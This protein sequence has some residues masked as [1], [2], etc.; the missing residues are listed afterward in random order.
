ML[1]LSLPLPLLSLSP[2]VRC[3][4]CECILEVPV[5]ADCGHSVC[6]GCVK[7]DTPADPT[8][9]PQD[10]TCPLCRDSVLQRAI[11][12]Y[13]ARLRQRFERVDHGGTQTALSAIYTE[14]LVTEAEAEA[15][16]SETLAHQHEVW[17]LESSY[18][19][20]RSS[21]SSS[22]DQAEL[23]GTTGKKRKNSG[24][25]PEPI[26][27]NNVFKPCGGGR[28][29]VKTVMT[30]G[31]AGVGKT[32][33][34]HRFVLDWADG[35]A[36][37]DVDFIFVFSFGTLNAIRHSW[38]NLHGLLLRLH[39][40]LKELQGEQLYEEC[41]VVL[42]FDGLDESQLD[43]NFQDN[44]VLCDTNNFASVDVLVTNL[45][46][47]NL[48]PSAQ[49]WVTS[50]PSAANQIPARYVDRVTEIHGFT[51]QQREE[52]FRKRLCE[53]GG[54]GVRNTLDVAAG[55]THTD[56]DTH[57][58][59]K[60]MVSQIKSCRSL[61][62][63][64]Q[65][66]SLCCIAAALFPYMLA[67]DE[68]GNNAKLVQ[69]KAGYD[70]K[71]AQV[72]TG[73][74]T[75]KLAL[76][77]TANSSN[78]PQ[79]LTE[80]FIHFLLRQ[81]HLEMEMFHGGDSHA[82][83]DV[84][85]SP[86]TGTSRKE[87]WHSRTS[88]H[89]SLD[90]EAERDGSS[91]G[92]TDR[93]SPWHPMPERAA[94]SE[95]V[96]AERTT[97][98]DAGVSS[99]A[100]KNRNT[101]QD[102]EASTCTPLDAE[103]RGKASLH[104]GIDRKASLD[105]AERAPSRDT[106]MKS[107]ASSETGTKRKASR[108]LDTTSTK[109]SCDV[110]VERD[111]SLDVVA[112]RD[113]PSDAGTWT[114]VMWDLDAES[115]AS[116]DAGEKRDALS[117]AGTGRKASSDAGTSRKASSYSGTRR[118]VSSALGTERGASSNLEAERDASLERGT[119]RK[120]SSD[121]GTS[122]DVSSALGM[123][124]DE[125]W[126]LE[127]EGAVSLDLEVERSFSCDLGNNRNASCYMEAERYSS[128]DFG[129]NRKASWDLEAD[130]ASSCDLEKNR[131]ASGY[132]EAERSSSCDR[133]ASWDLEAER[134]ASRELKREVLLRLAELAFT[135][136]GKGGVAGG[137][138][139]DAL[140]DC[141][142]CVGDATVYSVIFREIF[143]E[144]TQQPQVDHSRLFRF[145]HPSVQEFL[146][147]YFAVHCAVTCNAEQ[148]EEFLREHYAAKNQQELEL[149]IKN[150]KNRVLSSIKT[151]F[152]IPPLELQRQTQQRSE[153]D[154]ASEGM[155]WDLMRGVVERCVEDAHGSLDLFLRFLV[156]L[157]L[158][159]NQ[160]LLLCK[161]G[162]AMAPV[163]ESSSEVGLLPGPSSEFGSWT[164]L[165]G[166][167]S[168]AAALGL[169]PEA[170]Q[171]LGKVVVEHI[172]T[173]LDT[174]LAP[175]RCVSLV[176][177]L[178]EVPDDPLH[179]ELQKHL[180]HNHRL[181]R[182]GKRSQQQQQLP[183]S[184]P[185][186]PHRSSR[187]PG[188]EKQH[189]PPAVCSALAHWLLVGGGGEEVQRDEEAQEKAQE[190][191]L[192]VRRW[193]TSEKGHRRLLPA[194]RSCRKAILTGCEL[195]ESSV[196]L[197]CSVLPVLCCPI[198]EL[199]LSGCPLH[200]PWVSS[201]STQ[202][203]SATCRLEVLRLSSCSLSDTAG[204]FLSSVLSCPSSCLREL[205]LSHNLLGDR[206]AMLLSAQ[207][208]SKACT[209]H[210]LR[211]S[212]CGF[213][214]EGCLPLACGVG[215]AGCILRELDIRGNALSNIAIQILLN[216]IQ[217]PHGTLHTLRL[218]NAV[219]LWRRLGAMR[220]ACPLSL[221]PNTAHCHLLLSPDGSGVTHSPQPQDCPPHPDRFQHR[222]QV[223]SSL[224]LPSPRC[225]WEAEWRRHNGGVAV[226]V[227]Y[228]SIGRKGWG[229]DCLLGYNDQSWC[230]FYSH[231]RCSAWHGRGQTIISHSL[232]PLTQ[233]PPPTISAPASTM[234]RPPQPPPEPRPAPEPKPS[235]SR[236]R[237]FKPSLRVPSTAQPTRSPDPSQGKR[238][239][240]ALMPH[241]HARLRT[242]AQTQI[243]PHIN[244]HQNQQHQA[245]ATTQ[246]QH[247]GGPSLNGHQSQIQFQDQG[248]ALR[249]GVYVDSEAGCLAFYSVHWDSV[250]R[251]HTFHAEFSEPLY[252]AARVR[253]PHAT[254][255]L[256]PS[257]PSSGREEYSTVE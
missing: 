70:T 162:M 128:C 62:I 167:S 241:R 150:R 168:K 233:P 174:D 25:R 169:L 170:S 21:S 87:S 71:L 179:R 178:E 132:M 61:R 148:L 212:C 222:P 125:S 24:T 219:D 129:K 97:S 232:V 202:L 51:D 124:R 119:N 239:Q 200:D 257:M 246:Q 199:D 240:Q 41:R 13:K 14:L 185:H 249:V 36:N 10:Q 244:G 195:D 18:R 206:V 194:L 35:L 89:V 105:L 166:I 180:D 46:Q 214:D 121:A 73:S 224:P 198:S 118:D 85:A 116:L 33:S 245:R 96:E 49:V 216:R 11:A 236:R 175:D 43:L 120:T 177:C 190:E 56:L 255:T 6:E 217:E 205:D 103:V 93:K 106:A 8:S 60:T 113:A 39:P 203:K 117:D 7:T 94:A 247:P 231:D 134:A 19:L 251:L 156:G 59:V 107:N 44:Y 229:Q 201:L 55:H 234:Q 12:G 27:C 77:G 242:A 40:E 100:E 98:L 22:Q 155:I 111:K 226:G 95:V 50:R 183:Q 79:T 2:R 90:K 23:N 114:N 153:Q 133:N 1:S 213:S 80:M 171:E 32:T 86:D 67:Q 211:V 192:D 138:G 37:Q 143:Q 110:E 76:N 176:R 151:I 88:T 159:T 204:A 208:E 45:I 101:S 34:V 238:Q 68:Q 248:G 131:N 115:D 237:S 191:V 69:D 54:R 141:G 152:E 187:R 188:Q 173:L 82:S 160:N 127:V 20:Q 57:T 207:L 223:L 196:G 218:D 29:Y 72:E 146:A 161:E 3:D 74:S 228:G 230:L 64:C 65:M 144:E 149:G 235:P 108:D 225:Y 220:Y 104:S 26:S 81:L 109:A 66:P 165:P 227:A 52:Y 9:S 182:G 84:E 252:A 254:L 48:L 154:E 83:L 17:R 189:V 63:M 58:L 256:N 210:T 181:D 15:V 42:V 31:V 139:K 147:A 158:E 47:G 38:N 92:G 184:W 126:D 197:L 135:Q 157:S 30:R 137:I 28:G 136:L 164:Q 142:I 209:L 75:R 172:R 253:E 102:M 123:D 145:S 186:H 193:P 78:L 130:R 99:Y 16:A 53:D 112:A 4:V 221:D 243:Q 91:D 5:M 140:E 215:T 122:G 163:P 250:V